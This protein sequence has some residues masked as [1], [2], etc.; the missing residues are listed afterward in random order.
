MAPL[1]G[2]AF[3]PFGLRLD[4]VKRGTEVLARLQSGDYDLLVLDLGLGDI[5]GFDV[6]RALRAGPCDLRGVQIT[7]VLILSGNDTDEALAR[8]FGYGADDYVRKPF[9]SFNLGVR[10]LR[11]IRP[12]RGW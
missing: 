5:H 9:D 6:L 7:P 12:F 4:S 3:R 11:L 1:V 10:A 2:A 8:S